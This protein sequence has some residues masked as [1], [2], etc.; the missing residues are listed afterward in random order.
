MKTFPL[1]PQHEQRQRLEN[2]DRFKSAS[3]GILTAI[4][5]DAH[6]MYQLWIVLFITKCEERRTRMFI[7]TEGLRGQT[8]KGWPW[9]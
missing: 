3:N 1:H 9:S 2:P 5:V 7:G 4:D 8:E 6:R